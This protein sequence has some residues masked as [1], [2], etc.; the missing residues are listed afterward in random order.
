MDRR[1]GVLMPVSS[2]PGAYGIGCFSH[3]A[4]EFVDFLKETGQTYWQIL[5]LCQTGFGDSPYQSVSTFAGN[6]YFIDLNEFVE[7]GYISR[8]DLNSYDFGDNPGHVDY[9][10]MY[11][12]RYAALRKAYENS[13]FALNLQG[14]WKDSSNDKER[15][16]FEA[17]INDNTD[18][19]YDYALYS[20]IKADEN[21]CSL[22][23][24]DDA[25]R[26]REKKSIDE[27]ASVHRDDMRYQYFIQYFFSRQ[28][29]ALKAYANENGILIIGD[30]PIYVA[31][32]SADLWSHPELF[33]LDKDKRPLKVAGCPPDAFSKDGQLW[34]NP[35]YRWEVHKKDGY[36]WWIKR[37]E[38]AFKLYDIVRIDHFRGFESFWSV[39]ADAKTAAKGEWVKGPGLD[40]FDTLKKKLGDMPVIAEDLGFLTPEVLKMVKDS[41]YPGMRIVEFA[42]DKSNDNLYLPHMIPNNAVAYTGTHDNQT[43]TGWYLTLDDETRDFVHEYM[44]IPAWTELV[45]IN[46]RII[47]SLM[48]CAADTVIIPMQDYFALDDSARLNEPSTLGENNWCWR[49]SGI[50]QDEEFIRRMY[51][52]AWIYDRVPSRRHQSQFD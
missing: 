34:G 39:D 16:D 47:S 32:D 33:E 10:K 41:G 11:N 8:E 23:D 7:K 29:Q 48:K 9:G 20:V 1:C 22:M 51:R 12:A 3:E 6:P 35:V 2:L 45:D 26:L 15:N 38:H 24:W 52:T 13:P 36:S 28:W 30:V 4:Y 27:A 44:E 17:F 25:L 37:M 14:A 46:F 19:L 18:W 5:P 40:L 31:M 21:M 43:L 49:M 42:F 50:P